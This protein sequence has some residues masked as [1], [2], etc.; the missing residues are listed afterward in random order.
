[1]NKR[2][3]RAREAAEYLGMGLSTVWLLANQKKLHPI[4]ISDRITVFDKSDLDRFIDS[5]SEADSEEPNDPEQ[6]RTA[7]KAQL[8][9]M[10]AADIKELLNE[11]G[12]QL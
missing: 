6:T 3:Y 12:N 1:M 10:T 4:K 2:G 7:L 11:V 8:A 9:K 5:R